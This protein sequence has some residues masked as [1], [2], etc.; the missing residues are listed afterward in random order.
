M[1]KRFVSMALGLGLAAGLAP[2]GGA[3][4]AAECVGLPAVPATFACVMRR[5]LVEPE[6]NDD[7][8]LV[9]PETCV[10]VCI[11]EQDVPLVDVVI[12]DDEIVVVYH[13]GKCY[14]VGNFTLTTRWATSTNPPACP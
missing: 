8:A 4:Q 7:P 1:R 13:N 9:V 5:D 10:V 14:Y 11:D 12:H 3:A 2:V 6:V